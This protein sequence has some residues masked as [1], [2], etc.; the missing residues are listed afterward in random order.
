[1]GTRLEQLRKCA[2]VLLKNK[3]CSSRG[4]ETINVTDIKIHETNILN[5]ITFELGE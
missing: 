3:H 1:M 5:I 4:R 2:G